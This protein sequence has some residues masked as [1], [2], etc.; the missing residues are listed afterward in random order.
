MIRNLLFDFYF[1]DINF[2]LNIKQYAHLFQVLFHLLRTPFSI[3]DDFSSSHHQWIMQNFYI[4]S[5]SCASYAICS[6]TPCSNSIFFFYHLILV[7]L[8]LSVDSLKI[9]CIC[10]H[11]YICPCGC[12]NLHHLNGPTAFPSFKELLELLYDGFFLVPQF[13]L[14]KSRL[15]LFHYEVLF[16]FLVLPF[17]NQIPY[18]CLNI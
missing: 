11:L 3:L 18:S 2:Y 7:H 17:Q 8:M 10:Y 14:S 1:I 6:G 9:Y 5:H 16:L 12:I 4:M 13:A 15:K